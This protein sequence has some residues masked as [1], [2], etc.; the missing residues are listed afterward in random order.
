MLCL[1]KL[2]FSTSD[3]R[4]FH[5]LCGKEWNGMELDRVR[6]GVARAFVYEYRN[7]VLSEKWRLIF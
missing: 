4:V 2:V 5:L 1:P 7:Q 3:V 6:R